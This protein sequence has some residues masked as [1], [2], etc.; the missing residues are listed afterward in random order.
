[1]SGEKSELRREFADVL[2][3]P[4]AHTYARLCNELKKDEPIAT[5]WALRDA[6][7]SAVRFV[8]CLGLADLVRADAHGEEFERALAL[9][10]KPTGLS[11]GDWT[12]LVS[13]GCDDAI[14][15]RTPRLLPGLTTFYRSGGR[16]TPAGQALSRQLGG[17]RQNPQTPDKWNLTQWRNNVFGHPAACDNGWGFSFPRPLVQHARPPPPDSWSAAARSLAPSVLARWGVSGLDPP[18]CPHEAIRARIPGTGHLLFHS[19]TSS[20]WAGQQCR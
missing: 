8:A 3:R 17:P 9:L 2:P 16:L 1:M 4:L 20:L 15:T 14:E 5:A 18:D 6:W 12:H 10:F 13:T 11:L 19:A 7:E